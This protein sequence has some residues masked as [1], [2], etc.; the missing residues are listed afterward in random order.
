M[1][2]HF[3]TYQEAVDFLK[4]IGQWEYVSTH[5]FS[6]DGWSIMAEAEA[7]YKRMKENGEL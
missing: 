4:S 1:E 6:T 3:K 5:G 7:I 2:Q